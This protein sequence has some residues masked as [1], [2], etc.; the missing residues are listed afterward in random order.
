MCADDDGM[1][2]GEV[3]PCSLDTKDCVDSV[4]SLLW[5][6][7][8][9]VCARACVCMCVIRH[10]RLRG[11][12]GVASLD[13]VCVCVYVCA[14]FDTKDCVDSAVLLLWASADAVCE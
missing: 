14:S 4:V 9:A 2:W 3:E 13:A 12:C 5:V 1:D 7:A 10:E 8:K 6:F 11:F